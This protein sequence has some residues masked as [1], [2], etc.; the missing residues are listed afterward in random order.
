[1]SNQKHKLSTGILILAL[2]GMHACATIIPPKFYQKKTEKVKVK[3]ES[4]HFVDGA[5]LS[6]EPVLLSI[7]N[8]PSI[9]HPLHTIVEFVDINSIRLA[10]FAPRWKVRPISFDRNTS[11]NLKRV[12]K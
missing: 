10:S 5:N 4:A 8:I 2:I 3:N 7:R 11:M 9:N 12:K 6:K 1:M